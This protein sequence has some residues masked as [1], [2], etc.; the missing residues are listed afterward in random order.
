MYEKAG[1]IKENSDTVIVEQAEEIT[2]IIEETCNFISP[3]LTT[4]GDDFKRWK[5][6]ANNISYLYKKILIDIGI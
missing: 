3:D 4:N 1:I 2:K 5:Q 6:D